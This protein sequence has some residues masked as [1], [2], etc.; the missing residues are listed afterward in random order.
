MDSALDSLYANWELLQVVPY[1][2]AILPQY[3][4]KTIHSDHVNMTKFASQEDNGYMQVS[5]ELRRWVKGLNPLP[6]SLPESST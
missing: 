6:G 3:T 2:S 5:S 1:H 4:A